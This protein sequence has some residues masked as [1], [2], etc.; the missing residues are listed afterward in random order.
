MIISSVIIALTLE[1][2]SLKYEFPL[3]LLGILGGAAPAVAAIIVVYKLY[4]PEESQNYWC[5]VYRFKTKWIW[6]VITLLSPLVVGSGANLA[7]HFQL[8][9]SSLDVDDVITLP[10]MFAVSIFAGGA[11]ELGWRG[12]FQNILAAKC[13]LALTGFI[14]GIVWGIWHLPLFLIDVFAHYN[15]HFGIYLLSTIMYSQIITLVVAESRSVLLAVLLHAGINAFSNSGFN[16]PMELS[17]R[18]IV[19]MASVTL[20]VTMLL[21]RIDRRVNKHSYEC[22]NGGNSLCYLKLILDVINIDS[23]RYNR[24]SMDLKTGDLV[25]PGLN[26]RFS[27]SEAMSIDLYN[28]SNEHFIN[29]DVD[30]PLIAGEK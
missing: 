6:W 3:S 8:T 4:S 14:I 22:Q 24:A 9:S 16:I 18:I 11:E 12:I 25:V 30:N 29:S 26:G 10:I 20:L 23:T 21:I 19:Y 17:W 2:T 15:Y 28:S 1:Y 27:I 13:S 5:F 7:Q